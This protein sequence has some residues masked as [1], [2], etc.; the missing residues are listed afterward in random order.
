VIGLPG[1][2]RRSE[3]GLTIAEVLVYLVI[4]L[5]LMGGVYGLIIN[6]GR[7]Y[8]SQLEVTDVRNSVRGAASL[9]TWE[10]RQAAA[11][12]GD[13]YFVA[14]DSFAVRSIQA[15]GVVCSEHPT[16]TR[17]GLSVTAGELTATADDSALVFK[18]AGSGVAD[19]GWKVVKITTVYRPYDAST[20]GILKCFWGDATA[21]KGR[22][23]TTVPPNGVA[24]TT[25]TTVPDL[26][27][28]VT[29]LPATTYVDSVYMGA[30]FLAFR[31]I[32]YGIYQEGGRWWLG[33]KVGGALAYEKLTGPL[34]SNTDGGLVFVYRDSLGVITANRLLV[35]EV[36]II[37][38]GE[39]WGRAPNVLRSPPLAFRR[40]TVRT[41]VA[42]RG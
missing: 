9:L 38:R 32:Q 23:K 31:R 25:G 30:P 39:S 10:L 2:V 19:D 20:S 35:R 4:A 22:G 6:Q 40:D 28:A 27:V 18:A 41:R 34:R 33:R 21:G 16:L 3:A 13:L 17:Y 37:I 7:A 12:A 8:Q 14:T 1:R 36:E 26:G 5:I 42:L 15:T 24:S 11:S 29:G